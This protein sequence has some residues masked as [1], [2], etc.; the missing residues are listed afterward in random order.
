M[1]DLIGLITAADPATRNRSLDEVCAGLATSDLLAQGDALD[2]FRRRSDNLYERVRA[3][4]FLYGIHRFH[5]PR[6]LLRRDG[7]TT[8]AGNSRSRIPFSGYEL[9]LRRR[10]VFGKSSAL[11]VS[12]SSRPQLIEQG[13]NWIGLAG[14]DLF[15]FRPPDQHRNHID[16][17]ILEPLAELLRRLPLDLFPLCQ[18]IEHVRSLC[19]VAEV[20][21]EYR[22]KR[23]SN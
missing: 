14:S 22:I 21:C 3:L 5:L 10:F 8:S 16:I 1:P 23:L 11:F 2:V 4:F 6:E 15:R 17:I 20:G 9:L 13:I 12:E 7:A 19:Y 18:Q